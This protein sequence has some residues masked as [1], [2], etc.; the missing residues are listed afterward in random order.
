MRATYL[1][2]R[3]AMSRHNRYGDRT[4]DQPDL[5]SPSAP[6]PERRC[7]LCSSVLAPSN[8]DA[9]CR[10]CQL[11]VSAQLGRVLEE[12]WRDHP[13]G[14]HV[15]SERGRVARLL[16]VDTAHRYPRVSVA[17]V[18]RYVHH[19]VAEAWNGPRPEGLLA[20]HQDDDPAN[21]AADNLSWGSPAQNYA[22][23]V[24]NGRI[25]GKAE[26]C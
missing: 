20:L 13:D 26:N 4:D 21:P 1:R 2:G 17:G 24:R 5:W 9:W 15:V 10:E 18:K 8:G 16:R 25:R 12:R 23:A 7:E 6:P 22:D 14:E 11:L 19:L 3:C